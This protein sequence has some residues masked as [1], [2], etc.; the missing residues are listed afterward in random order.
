MHPGAGKVPHG[1]LPAGIQAQHDDG[2]PR[3]VLAEEAARFAADHNQRLVLAVGL[4]VDAD[5][6]ARVA[7]DEDFAAAHR[8][9]R[10]VSAG[11][12]HHNGAGVHGVAGL[13]LRVALHADGSAVQVAAEVVARHAANQQVLAADARADVPLTHAV[14]D[15]DLRILRDPDFFIELLKIF[16]VRI[17]PKHSLSLPA[18][19]PDGLRQTP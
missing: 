12:F 8:V 18:W 6:V 7:P 10:G 15:E 19:R 14:L 11:A 17:N 5:A 13:V 4:H 2:P 9:P 1:D 3:L 16:A